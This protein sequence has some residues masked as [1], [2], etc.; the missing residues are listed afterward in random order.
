MSSS[1]ILDTPDLLDRES[2]QQDQD[3]VDI[4]E[5][6]SPQLSDQS[7]TQKESEQGPSKKD[8]DKKKEDSDSDMSRLGTQPIGKLILSIAL[9]TMVA[10][11]LTAMYN[12]ADSS[13]VGLFI[14]DE[15]LAALSAYLPIEYMFT[16]YLP[17]AMGFGIAALI[18]PALGAG[19]IKQA[20]SHFIEFL[21]FG[22]TLSCVVLPILIHFISEPIIEW[23]GVSPSVMELTKS[24]GKVIGNYGPT[25]Y[26]L[27]TAVGP[28]LRCCGSQGAR[29]SMFCQI[30]SSVFNI[31]LDVLLMGSAVAMGIAGAATATVISQISIGVCLLV[32]WIRPSSKAI[33]HIKPSLV[34]HFKWKHIGQIAGLGLGFYVGRL[35]VSLTALFGNRVIASTAESLQQ[36]TILQA[37]LGL[38][39]R[40]ISLATMPQVGLAQGFA[41]VV[42]FNIGAKNY[43]RVRESIRTTTIWML[44]LGGSLTLLLELGA[45]IIM[46]IFS[47]N[48]EMVTVSARLVRIS[49]MAC[50]LGPFELVS[51]CVL[52]VEKRIT[53]SFLAQLT[54][55]LVQLPCTFLPLLTGNPEHVFLSILFADIAVGVVG[56]TILYWVY[57]RY[58]KL[59]LEQE[60]SQE[61][62]VAAREEASSKLD[63]TGAESV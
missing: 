2:S 31:G 56:L 44:V 59:A 11:T 20:N 7:Q 32:Y 34:K 55:P 49:A 58:G 30:I 46:R 60:S 19:N 54:R 26:L 22:F 62:L 63:L 6:E 41:P 35:P 40:V 16:F 4:K 57:Q 14:G 10:M 15:G 50:A 37:S 61:A 53:L 17:L 23:I 47:H 3:V 13:C 52:Q 42:G 25:G 27:V 39:S 29:L 21:I 48:E 33:L 8:Q 38:V 18:S 43:R 51:S 5:I 9:P 24:Y 45:P 28:L 1:S 36:T 12:V